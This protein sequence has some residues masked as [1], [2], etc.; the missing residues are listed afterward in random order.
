MKI[1]VIINQLVLKLRNS[2][3]TYV[4]LCEL[5]LFGHNI[6]RKN[7]IFF[8]GFLLNRKKK[9]VNLTKLI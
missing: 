9:I 5:Y 7:T 1:I 2:D 4:L 8:M 6:Q 3:L